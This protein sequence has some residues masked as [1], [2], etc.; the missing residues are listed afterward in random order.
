MTSPRLTGRLLLPARRFFVRP[1]SANGRD[2]MAIIRGVWKVLR[3]VGLL[4]LLTCL[5][6]AVLIAS[7]LAS[8]L[9]GGGMAARGRVRLGA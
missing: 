8:L 3:A 4:A 5:V 6:S 2:I 7:C 1:G 9:S